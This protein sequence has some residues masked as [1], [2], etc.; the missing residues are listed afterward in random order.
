MRARMCVRVRARMCVRVRARMCVREA[1]VEW[2]VCVF[3]RECVY[4]DNKMSCLSELDAFMDWQCFRLAIFEDVKNYN[5]SFH[6][7]P[8]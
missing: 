5:R 7:H 4:M 2:L 1:G 6:D 3:L 8:P